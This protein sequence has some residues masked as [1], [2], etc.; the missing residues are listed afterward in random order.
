MPLLHRSDSKRSS[1]FD[2]ECRW[3]V[4]FASTLISTILSACVTPTH[5]AKAEVETD[6]LI[7]QGDL[8]GCVNY[9]DDEDSG[10]LNRRRWCAEALGD[11]ARAIQ[12][13]QTAA[14][15][16]PTLDNYFQNE[17]RRIQGG[18]PLASA[19]ELKTLTAAGS[20]QSDAAYLASI[21]T[22]NAETMASL[23]NLGEAI[24]TGATATTTPATSSGARI[25]TTSMQSVGQALVMGS[26]ASKSGSS[27]GAIP[28]KTDVGRTLSTAPNSNIGNAAHSGG[29]D[30]IAPANPAGPNP[31]KTLQNA[32]D[33]TPSGEDSM[34]V[35]LDSESPSDSTVETVPANMNADSA[36]STSSSCQIGPKCAAA[37][38]KARSAGSLNLPNLT[39]SMNDAAAAAYCVAFAA[40]E[41]DRICAVEFRAN[42][43]LNC[44]IL[45]DR[46]KNIDVNSGQAALTTYRAAAD[47]QA[48]KS[49][50]CKF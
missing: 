15:R 36:P 38:S 20:L 10:I 42:G 18:G 43:E 40:A 8:F 48:P 22:E 21:Q 25:A 13:L 5:F 45:A 37:V 9:P 27:T 31:P 32:T 44:A 50:S 49:P 30:G 12:L 35:V 46:Q 34:G 2:R 39:D 3:A 29:G 33:F 41:T 17:I 6:R 11:R 24:I 14:S 19:N 7:I 47:P 23:G 26:S 28:S 16:D 1:D 4:V